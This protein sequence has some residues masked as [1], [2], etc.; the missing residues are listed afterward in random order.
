MT[1]LRECANRAAQEALRTSHDYLAKHGHRSVLLDDAYSAAERV[2]DAVDE[3]ER[4]VD[5]AHDAADWRLVGGYS[6]T[7]PPDVPLADA[8]DWFVYPAGVGR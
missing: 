3:Y 4:L 1:H 8:G 7:Y 2:V 5:A 6:E